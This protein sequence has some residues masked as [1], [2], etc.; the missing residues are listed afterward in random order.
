MSLQLFHV[1]CLLVGY[2]LFYLS[3]KQLKQSY[4]VFFLL[5]KSDLAVRLQFL[6]CGHFPYLSWHKL[7]LEIQYYAKCLQRNIKSVRNGEFYKLT[8]L[9]K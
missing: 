4:L 6:A 2:L 8:R 7:Y 5:E 9:N 1:H 3:A